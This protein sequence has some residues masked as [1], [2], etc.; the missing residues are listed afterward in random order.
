[1]AA[2]GQPQPWKYP[3][4][5]RDTKSRG[6]LSVRWP[7][8]H[9]V[10]QLDLQQLSGADEIPCHANVRVRWSGVPAW[11]IVHHHHG[12]GVCRDRRPEHLPGMDQ[13]RVE[14]ALSHILHPDQPSTRVE[15]HDLE[16]FH[17]ILPVL[18]PQQIG[19]PFGRVQK[20]GFRAHLRRHPPRQRE[21]GLERDRLVTTDA[22]D[23][24]DLL[25]RCPR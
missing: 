4:S 3:S 15:Q 11:M 6:R 14:C 9:M 16:V 5:R 10:Q 18:I 23:R 20:R 24:A 17:L 19:D 21:C 8:D 22:P 7:Q 25:K 2:V 13:Q 12:R 1:M